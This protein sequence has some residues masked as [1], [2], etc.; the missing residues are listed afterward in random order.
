[1]KFC[2][3]VA[4]FLAALAT[5]NPVSHHGSGPYHISEFYASK[6]HNS[7]TCI[8]DFDVTAPG[9]DGAVHCHASVDAGFS[10][11]TWLAYV[12]EGAGNCNNSAV[13]WTFFQPA[14]PVGSDAQF[15]V[16]VNGVKGRRIIP[17]SDISVNLNNETNPFDNDVYYSGP[18]EFD[19]T[20][21]V[22]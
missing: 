6:I 13:A 8:Y 17:G 14:S 16:T 12:Y 7:G 20:E 5:A 21:F 3:S 18:R 10:G 1:M 15:N 19:I 11:A 22:K 2:S 4:L 9:L